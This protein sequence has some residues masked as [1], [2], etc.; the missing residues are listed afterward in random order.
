MQICYVGQAHL[1]TQDAN[2]DVHV[3]SIT[4]AF[5]R[6]IPF[7]SIHP[8]YFSHRLKVQNKLRLSDDKHYGNP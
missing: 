5:K 4:K 3:N 6:A 7:L 2:P 1:D 8:G